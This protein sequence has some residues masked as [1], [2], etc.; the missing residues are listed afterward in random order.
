MAGMQGIVGGSGS[1]AGGVAGN[2]QPAGA[3]GGG[4]SGGTVEPDA[5]EAD[6]SCV[7]RDTER[8][9]DPSCNGTFEFCTAKQY[10]DRG[11][12]VGGHIDDNCDGIADRYCETHTV[13]EEGRRLTTM[14]STFCDDVTN[15]CVELTYDGNEVTEISDVDC[16][17]QD[18]YCTKSVLDDEGRELSTTTDYECNG[19]ESCRT[20][21]YDELGRPVLSEYD[22][23]CDGSPNTCLSYEYDGETGRGELD[24]G[25]DGAPESCSEQVLAADGQWL[26]DVNYEGCGDTITSCTH[27]VF[28]EHRNRVGVEHDETCDGMPDE[29]AYWDYECLL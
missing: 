14:I 13:D 25:C 7:W 10:D 24:E 21:S 11:F 8:R 1:G 28:D 29:C 16:D 6:G 27:G 23:G 9:S 15:D 4:G 26:D 17:G 3:G 18:V 19:P 12:E 5:G 22:D 20:S 2:A